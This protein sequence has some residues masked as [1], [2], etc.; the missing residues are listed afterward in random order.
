MAV[1]DE[2]VLVFRPRR[3]RILA[4]VMAV[5]LCGLVVFGWFALPVSLRD[6]FTLSQRLTLLALLALLLFVMGAIA[7]SY[8]KADSRGLQLRNG[9]RTYSVA[10]SRVHKIILRPGDPWGLL[11][12]KPDDGR[13][14]EVDLDAEKRQ[15]MG[16]Q[17]N[18]G[19]SARLAIEALRVR[20]Q[21]AVS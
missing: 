17:R 1:L 11:L 8:V 4:A 10:W 16:I 20:H 3:L 13:A 5:A 19:A 14:F 2:E 7:S 21:R 12:L 6:A 18:D 15:M 9:L